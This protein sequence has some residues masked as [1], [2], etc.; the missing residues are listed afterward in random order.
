MFLFC[1]QRVKGRQ[2]VPTG[3]EQPFFRRA[4]EAERSEV[5]DVASSGL[6]R[7]RASHF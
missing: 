3:L 1:S 5:Q 7:Q 4:R 2:E 6:N